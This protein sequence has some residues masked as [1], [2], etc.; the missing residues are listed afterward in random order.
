M[1]IVEIEKGTVTFQVYN[2]E[3]MHLAEAFHLARDAAAGCNPPK[4]LEERDDL[5]QLYNALGMLFEVI[6]WSEVPSQPLSHHRRACIR[7]DGLDLA[8]TGE[9]ILQLAG[10]EADHAA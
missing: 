2:Y 3:A 8:R 6:S 4:H 5:R 7:G 9:T 1:R 10:E